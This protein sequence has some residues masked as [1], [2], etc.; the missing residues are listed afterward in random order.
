MLNSAVQYDSKGAQRGGASRY[1]QNACPCDRSFERV[2]VRQS[3]GERSFPEGNYLR[4]VATLS[5]ALPVMQ[6]S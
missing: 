6:L 1:A 5:T 4:H 3:P 2:R